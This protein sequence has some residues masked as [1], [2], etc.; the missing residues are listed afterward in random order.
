MRAM[1]IHDCVRGDGGVGVLVRRRVYMRSKSAAREIEGDG[2]GE[3][4]EPQRRVGVGL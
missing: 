1:C 3:E 2:S 4:E